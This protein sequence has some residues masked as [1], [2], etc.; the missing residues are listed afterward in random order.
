MC[1]GNE[2]LA[3]SGWTKC[4][5]RDCLALPPRLLGLIIEYGR[6]GVVVEGHVTEVTSHS[7][8]NPVTSAY[9]PIHS[10]SR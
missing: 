2:E 1:E 7:E 6:D 8:K 10:C 3:R 4:V 5:S 9:I